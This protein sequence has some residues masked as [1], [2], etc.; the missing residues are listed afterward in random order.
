MGACVSDELDEARRDVIA[1]FVV[2]QSE[3]QAAH[4]VGLRVR[5]QR[6]L[7]VDVFGSPCV[8]GARREVFEALR[9]VGVSEMP[10]DARHECRG[11]VEERGRHVTLIGFPLAV[12]GLEPLAPV[13][14]RVPEVGLVRCGVGSGR[15]ALRRTVRARRRGRRSPPIAPSPARALRARRHPDRSATSSREPRRWR[16][17]SRPIPGGSRACHPNAGGGGDPARSSARGRRPVARPR[18]HGASRARSR[19]RRTGTRRSVGTPA[20]RPS[21]PSARGGDSRSGS[22]RRCRGSS[23]PRSRES[24]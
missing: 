24:G 15:R 22:R 21:S 16:R 14:A 20:N 8:G 12:A 7:G 3:C 6:P 23:S 11:A 1:G 2:D 4:V 13:E 17:P 18:G 5:R 19:R 9:V 10:A